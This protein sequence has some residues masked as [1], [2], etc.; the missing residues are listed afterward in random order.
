MGSRFPDSR[1]APSRP[2]RLRDNYVRPPRGFL[3]W[4]YEAVGLWGYD[5]IGSTFPL[6]VVEFS[7]DNLRRRIAN[8]AAAVRPGFSFM[9]ASEPGERKARR[10]N[11]SNHLSS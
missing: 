4:G 5:R 6:P 8:I 2:L 3:Q 1:S 7:N 11:R 10:S 9:H